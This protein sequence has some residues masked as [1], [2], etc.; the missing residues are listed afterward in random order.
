MAKA[1]LLSRFRAGFAAPGV[2][3]RIRGVQRWRARLRSKI[4]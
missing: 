4:L 2:L 1:M 3:D